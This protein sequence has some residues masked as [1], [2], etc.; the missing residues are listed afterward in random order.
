MC[1]R[2][3]LPKDVK[4]ENLTLWKTEVVLGDVNLDE[5]VD[6]TDVS[7]IANVNLNDYDPA[8]DLDN[9]GKIDDLDV[10]LAS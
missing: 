2:D 1:R 7:I 6:G 9:S 3:A 10:A 8:L 4:P 5:I